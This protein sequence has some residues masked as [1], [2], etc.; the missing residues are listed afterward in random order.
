MHY[1]LLGFILWV[2]AENILFVYN[3]KNQYTVKTIFKFSKPGFVR[4]HN[5]CLVD[6][7]NSYFKDLRDYQS[8]SSRMLKFIIFF[9]LLHRVNSSI[10]AMNEIQNDGTS[11]YRYSSY[12]GK[13][14]LAQ[15]TR[16]LMGINSLTLKRK[17]FRSLK[18]TIF[19]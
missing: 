18:K 12:W 16:V 8:D 15:F 5:V 9:F 1:F 17:F 3:T 7:S 14:Y 19:K 10:Q 4:M 13:I 6:F 11:T 2:F